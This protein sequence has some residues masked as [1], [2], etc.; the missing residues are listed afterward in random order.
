MNPQAEEGSHIIVVVT[1]S[2]ILHVSVNCFCQ[3]T[4]PVPTA[5]K[6]GQQDSGRRMESRRKVS[7]EELVMP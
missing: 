2:S 3:D 6:L 4:P 5:V 1:F 7:R